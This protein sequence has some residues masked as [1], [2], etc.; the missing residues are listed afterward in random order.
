[1][2]VLNQMG[3]EVSD[4]DDNTDTND[5]GQNSN[6]SSGGGLRKQLEQA[7]TELKTLKAANETLQKE[8]RTSKISGLLTEKKL[9]AK[10]ARLIPGDIEPTKEAV[11]KWFEE[12]G[13]VFNIKRDETTADEGAS[14]EG[15]GGENAKA[16]ME[17][18]QT[19]RQ[20]GAVTGGAVPPAKAADLLAKINDPELTH[21]GLIALINAHGGGVGMG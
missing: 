16:D 8:A 19:M 18:I 2:C 12:Y 13:D 7:L 20:M 5:G 6:S 3:A 9:D 14:A 10:V 1:M 4:W 11:D 17:Y 21:E 15:A